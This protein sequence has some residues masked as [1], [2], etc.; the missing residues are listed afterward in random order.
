[1]SNNRANRYYNWGPYLHRTKL[2]QPLCREILARGRQ[3]HADH[4]HN[5]A[6]VVERQYLLGEADRNYIEAVL[7]DPLWTYVRERAL[8]HGEKVSVASMRVDEVWINIMRSGDFNPPHNHVGGDI[9]FVLY[10]RIP[11]GLE[12]EYKDNKSTNA[13]PGT[14][15]FYYGQP[16]SWVTSGHVIL[17]EEGDLLVFPAQL[18]HFVQ[19]YRTPC[20]RVSVAGN[21][22]SLHEKLP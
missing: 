20:E 1:M 13:G 2:P 5:L 12:E 3:A 4:S 7:Q 8:Y 11:E 15:E 10:L 19:P 14:I 21:I 6:G 17:P 9:S 18:V 16:D 22:I